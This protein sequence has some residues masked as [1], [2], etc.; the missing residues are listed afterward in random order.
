MLRHI[1][2]RA[3][4]RVPTASNAAIAT[5]TTSLLHTR[6]TNSQATRPPTAVLML[7]M[8]G[9]ADPK[10]TGMFLSNLFADGEIIDLG[11]FQFAGQYLAKR[12]T[13]AVEK[14]YESIGGS[15]ITKW[16]ELQGEAMCKKLDKLSPE[17]AP[18]K[19]YTTFRYVH[20]LTE[21]VSLRCLMQLHIDCDC[22][23]FRR[24][25]PS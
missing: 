2:Q 23:R 18:H 13:R 7:N 1:A 10:D 25:A 15:P 8:G 22:V 5:T 16:T 17:T 19:H 6:H 20:P 4:S 14:Q 11:K 24:A 9:P 3:A 21:D 12:R